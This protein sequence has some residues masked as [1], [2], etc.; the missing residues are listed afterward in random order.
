MKLDE[1]RKKVMLK[2]KLKNTE[3]NLG[4]SLPLVEGENSPAAKKYVDTNELSRSS[5]VNVPNENH[6]QSV[7]L[8]GLPKILEETKIVFC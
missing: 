3:I 1:K 6:S 2:D 4:K 7:F 8:Q 5:E